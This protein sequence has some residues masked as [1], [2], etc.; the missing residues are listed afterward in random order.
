MAPDLWYKKNKDDSAFLVGVKLNCHDKT[1]MI[2]KRS[3][4]AFK[5]DIAGS[6]KTEEGSE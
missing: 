1:D 3:Q 2:H 4:T 5:T 6:G